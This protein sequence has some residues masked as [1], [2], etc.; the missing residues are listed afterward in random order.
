MGLSFL[1]MFVLKRGGVIEA[2]G[3]RADRVHQAQFTGV[4][5]QAGLC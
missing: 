2:K 1:K 5:Q 3:L 4:Q